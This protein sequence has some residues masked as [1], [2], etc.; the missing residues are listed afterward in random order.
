MKHHYIGTEHL[1]LGLV[2]RARASPPECWR[3]W[4][5]AWTRCVRRCSR[6][7]AIAPPQPYSPVPGGRRAGKRKAA[8]AQAQA[9]RA[10]AG[11]RP[12]NSPT[13]PATWC[14]W[15]ARKRRTTMRRS[16]VLN[17]FC[18]PCCAPKTPTSPACSPPWV[19]TWRLA[20]RGRDH[21]AGRPGPRRDTS[22]THHGRRAGGHPCQGGGTLAPAT[23]H[24]PRTPAARPGARGREP[25]RRPPGGPR[26]S[27]PAL[28]IRLLQALINP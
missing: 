10:L 7:S 22:R 1:L 13:W 8:P 18:W 20:R 23:H 24:R 17:K 11:S 16:S 14:G 15:Q 26:F 25:R 4:A 3:A 21:A 19:A 12:P 6:S 9:G 5:S 27:L 2:A 28:Y